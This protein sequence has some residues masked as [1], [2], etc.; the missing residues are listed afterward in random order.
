LHSLPRGARSWEND[1]PEDE[2]ERSPEPPEDARLTSL[3]ERLQRA[4]HQEAVR[5]GQLKKPV[6][7]NFRLGNQVL[8]YLIGGPL[9]GGLIGWLL[10]SW[11]GT[12]P[13][14]LLVMAALGT[15]AGFRSIIRISNRKPGTGLGPDNKG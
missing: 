4:K 3:E 10:D 9:G 7:E 8:S 1:V 2:P 13:W 15:A 5:T 6:D 14:L 12:S 11:F